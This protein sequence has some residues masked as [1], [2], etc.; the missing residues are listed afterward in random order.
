[1]ITKGSIARYALLPGFIPRLLALFTSGFAHMAY[2]MALIYGLTGLLPRSHP[3]L[4]PQ[5]FGRY[6]M[7]H[8]IAE[9]ANNLVL[10][11]ENIDQIAVFIILLAG[12]VLLLL[13]FALLII[14]LVTYHP[15]MAT[16]LFQN[17][18]TLH[19]SVGPE[20][21]IAFIVLDNVF[22]IQNIFN[23]CISNTGVQCE[24]LVGN[25][26]PTPTIYPFPF[27]LGLHTMLEFYTRGIFM[28]AV[29]VLIYFATTI[30][31]ETAATGTPFGQRY[32]KAW[33]PIRIIFF[34]GLLVPLNA[35]AANAGLN[36]AQIITFWTARWG[37]NLASNL[38]GEFNQNLT[39]TYLGQQQDLIASPNIPEIGS[40]LQFIY[41]AKV[42]KIAEQVS[43]GH[44][45]KPYLVR[46]TPPAYDPA[47]APADP[48]YIEF[49]PTS[50]T[51]AQTFAMNGNIHIRFGTHTTGTTDKTGVK[52]GYSNYTGQVFPNCGDI[53]IHTTDL[54]ETGSTYIQQE[55]YRML[56]TMWTDPDINLSAKC[57]YRRLSEHIPDP[58][59]PD[60]PDTSFAENLIT[61]Y[62]NIIETAVTNGINSQKGASGEFTVPPELLEKG[63]AGAAIWYNRIARM[64][65]AVTTAVF[66][67][68]RPDT[69]PYIMEVIATQASQ[70][71]E[72][73]SSDTM[74]NPELA[75]GRMANFTRPNDQTIAPILL[76]AHNVWGQ[77]ALMAS[78][79]TE[80]TGNIIIDT[81]N[82]IVGTSGLFDMR[83]NADIH[84]LAQLSAL[85]KGMMEATVRNAAYATAGVI[86]PGLLG[87]TE[88]FAGK[89]SKVAGNFLFVI[90]TLS[91]GISVILYYILPF[92]PFIYFL[93]ALSGWIK[94]LFEAIVAMPLWAMAHIRIDGEGLPGPSATNGYFLL[95]EIMLRPSLILFGLLAGISI[96][97]ASVSVLN[98]IFDLVVSNVGG[99]DN[100]LENEI[101]SGAS[102]VASMLQYSRSSVDAF[103]FT[104]M[105]AVICYLMGVSAFKLVDLI[106][107]QI[108]RWMGVTVPSFQENAGDPTRTLVSQVYKTSGLIGNQVRGQVQ[109]NLALITST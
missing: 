105:Y 20:Q 63:W 72:N 88:D 34:F 60:W 91:I 64:N 96:F 10:K 70:Q 35:G 45:V 27:H 16:T 69:Y 78:N 68:P 15:A 19:G 47:N 79:Y 86:G 52:D 57:N 2:Y 89:I 50:F 13:Q 109:G 49:L 75:D 22:G 93:F 77:D 32:N 102:T 24:D 58:N 42:C 80:S 73:I 101:A 71:N 81:I 104:I 7:R 53:V 39:G 21:D 31:A 87:M 85:G 82:T 6:G 90:L 107:N 76:A 25:A 65:G 48:D 36:A 5:N 40:L 3:Y 44:D 26:L 41:V 11:R 74:F 30:V 56:K 103:A 67:I 33:V 84:P 23:S 55:Y 94:S 43:Y 108:L 97:S 92:L 106:P 29:I 100:R 61:K 8:V 9:A 1:M 83:K 28:V 51:N 14:T 46:P 37:S 98:N 12:I 59:C 54:Y 4:N 99:F 62:N 38:W 17:P 18:S 66:N 95:L